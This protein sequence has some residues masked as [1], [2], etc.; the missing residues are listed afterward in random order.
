MEH[1]WITQSH[2]WKSSN[3][4]DGLFQWPH[5]GAS[6]RPDGEATTERRPARIIEISF[7]VARSTSGRT[8]VRPYIAPR[9]ILTWCVR[10]LRRRGG[11]IVE[12]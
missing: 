3:R 2:R 5:H 9:S 10:T 11:D 6:Y 8:V 1:K 12:I 4:G 7:I